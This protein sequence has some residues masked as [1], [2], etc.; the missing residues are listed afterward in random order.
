MIYIVGLG[1]PGEEYKKTRHNTGRI[2]LD[3][4]RKKIDADDFEFNKKINALVSEGK[5]GK[6]KVMLIEPETF[7]NKSGLSLKSLIASKKKAGDLVVIYDDLDLPIGKMKISFN[8]GTG[9]HRGLESVAKQIKTLEF[10]RFR[11]GI[12]PKTPSG[13]TKKPSGEQAVEK[14]ILGAFKD[15]EMLE[16]KKIGKHATEALEVFVEEGVEMAMTRFN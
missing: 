3:I 5:I 13:K 1:N 4:I 6:E 12:S 7:M 8:R 2:I 15:P 9:G 14:H 11:V 10:V 16:L